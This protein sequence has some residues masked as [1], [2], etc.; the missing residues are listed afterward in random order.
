MV[1]TVKLLV[2]PRL[3]ISVSQ[4]YSFV[5]LLFSIQPLKFFTAHV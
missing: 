5:A 1:E 2:F 4:S 3:T